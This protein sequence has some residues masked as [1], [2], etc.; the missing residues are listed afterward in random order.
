MRII[1]CQMAARVAVRTYEEAPS[2]QRVKLKWS[3]P[4]GPAHEFQASAQGPIRTL[5]RDASFLTLLFVF[6]MPLMDTLRRTNGKLLQ[7]LTR[8]VETVEPYT[9][10]K[11]REE[12][13]KTH[14]DYTYSMN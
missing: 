6:A 9:T 4:A 2:L 12:S 13:K 1:D 3:L 10:S 7:V 8:S 5:T 11:T 14:S